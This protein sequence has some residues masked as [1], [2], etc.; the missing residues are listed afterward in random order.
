M[1]I[2]IAQLNYIIGDFEG[3][4]TKMLDAVKIAKKQGADIVE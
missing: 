1:K 4:T 2:A 3:N